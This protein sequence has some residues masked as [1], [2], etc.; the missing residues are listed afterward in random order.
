MDPIS[1]IASSNF[2]STE[3]TVENIHNLYNS[4]NNRVTPLWNSRTPVERP[5]SPTTI[6]LIRPY[7]VW[8]TVCSVCAI[9]DRRPSLRRD[10]RPGHMGFSPDT[11]TFSDRH[12]T[13]SMLPARRRSDTF[14]GLVGLIQVLWT[15]RIRK[16]VIINGCATLCFM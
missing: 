13:V 12:G 11:N 6:P 7:F 10:Q 14:V 9:H 16:A 3:P 5:P 4:S 15:S 2:V 8:W 1:T